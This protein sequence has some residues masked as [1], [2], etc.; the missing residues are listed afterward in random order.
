VA[1]FIVFFCPGFA[2]AKKDE[3]F[4]AFLPIPG[5]MPEKI[6]GGKDQKHEEAGIF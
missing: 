6:E 4:L 3:N 2:W 5:G 1:F